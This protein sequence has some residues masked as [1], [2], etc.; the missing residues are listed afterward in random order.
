MGGDIGSEAS[1]HCGTGGVA[2]REESRG[3]DPGRVHCGAG[4]YDGVFR[5]GE[6]G[7]GATPELISWFDH[8]IVHTLVGSEAP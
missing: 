7:M 6:G 5:H 1:G 2:A 4:I 3:M 8:T